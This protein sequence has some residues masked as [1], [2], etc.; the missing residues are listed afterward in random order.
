MERSLEWLTAEDG[1]VPL[2][3]HA[4]VARGLLAYLRALGT[5][6]KRER[7]RERTERGRRR[8]NDKAAR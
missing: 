7:A 4:R 6:I 8:R 3:L 1:R 5:I 2:I